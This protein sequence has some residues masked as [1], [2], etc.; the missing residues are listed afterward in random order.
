MGGDEE[1]AASCQVASFISIRSRRVDKNKSFA[2]LFFSL[3]LAV[4]E[5]RV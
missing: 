5:D 3:P 2:P 1:L 4:N